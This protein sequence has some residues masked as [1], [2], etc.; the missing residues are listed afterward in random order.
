MNTMAS[1][2]A[3]LAAFVV[4]VA[5]APA[6][7]GEGM[8]RLGSEFFLLLTL[9]TMWNLLAGYCGLMSLGQ[10]VFFGLGG[11][12]V[13][14]LSNKFG[15]V[16]YW[17]LPAAPLFSGAAAALCAI[18]LF[19]LRDAYFAIGSWVLAEIIALLVVKSPFFGGVSG[20]ALETLPLINFDWFEPTIFWISGGVAAAGLVGSYLLP[21][22]RLGFALMTIR[23]N[24]LA[25]RSIGVDVWRARFIAFVISGAGCG[26]AGSVSL[27]SDLTVSNGTAFS[28]NWVV[29]MMFIVIVGGIGTLE[30]PILG[31]LIHFAL[32]EV[33]T[34][35]L[36]VS[37]TWYLVAMGLVA[38]VTMLFSPTGLWPMIRRRLGFEPL[39]V[40]RQLPAHF[41]PEAAPSATAARSV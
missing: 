27:L 39:S 1:R 3:V 19:R 37:G 38:V 4:F 28:P 41:R 31:T 11:Y 29:A 40:S 30:G 15:I 7:I 21:R 26:L 33:L 24:E 12:C 32:R 9:A 18:F 13:Y 5:V 2:A 8:E 34:V 23:D 36:G 20:L 17:V 14:F 25:A 35:M 6:F 10:Q 16:P 22:S